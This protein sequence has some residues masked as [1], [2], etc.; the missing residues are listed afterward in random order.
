MKKLLIIALTSL[1]ALTAC[2]GNKEVKE[3]PINEAKKIVSLNGTLTEIVYALNQGDQ[4]VAVDVTSTYPEAAT[5]LT[6][7]GHTNAATAESILGAEPTDVIGFEDE[8]KPQLVE[9]LT[10]AGVHVQLFKREYSVDGTKKVISDVAKWL[11]KQGE[12]EK[13]QTAI[14]TDIKNL[15]KLEKQPSVLFVYARG[16]GMMMVAGDDTPLKSMIELAGGKNAVGG[17]EQYKPLTPEAVID[18]NPDLLLMFES[19]ANSLN[20]E[21]G[22]M[23]I[24]GFKLT[25]AGKKKNVVSM[26]GQLLS[27]FGPR[28]GKALLELNAKLLEISKQ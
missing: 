12:G 16:A 5:K 2:N 13:L 1:T 9:Q 7:L 18:A 8:V 23:E 25:T 15:K 20:G 14:D 10:S 6:N 26:D 27:G 28:V 11:G 21:Q 19:G 3:E 4:L 24:P 17:F 22:I